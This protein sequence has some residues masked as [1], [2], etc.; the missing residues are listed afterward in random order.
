MARKAKNKMKA[1]RRETEIVM[2]PR[3]VKGSDGTQTVE[4]FQHVLK[5]RELRDYRR[6]G[7]NSKPMASDLLINLMMK[8]YLI[9][10][11]E[12]VI[13]NNEADGNV[14]TDAIEVTTEII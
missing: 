14:P 8:N 10:P 2:V 7:M 11:E 12:D 9:T 5:G 13:I 1:W 3:Q 4:Y 6:M